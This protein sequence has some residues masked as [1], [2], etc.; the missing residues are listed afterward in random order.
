MNNMIHPFNAD[1]D[2]VRLVTSRIL[3]EAPVKNLTEQEVLQTLRL[4]QLQNLMADP[5]RTSHFS[6]TVYQDDHRFTDLPPL[7]RFLALLLDAECRDL[8]L[9]SKRCRYTF[10]GS[11]Y[12]WR[13]VASGCVIIESASMITY[14]DYG[15]RYLGR[16]W[17]VAPNIRTLRKWIE[18]N[19]TT[20]EIRSLCQKI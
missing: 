5:Q 9:T 15:G 20:N 4:I 16:G 6:V 2:D 8:L 13:K 10:G 7:D 11:Q 3:A 18:T 19:I 14:A 12:T 1:S 17:R